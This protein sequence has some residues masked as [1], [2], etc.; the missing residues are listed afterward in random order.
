MAT[1]DSTIGA[2][3][4]GFALS[5]LLFGMTTVQLNFYLRHFPDDS[6]P[7]KALTCIVWL[8]E[9]GHQFCLWH[10]IHWFLVTNF[11]TGR[12]LE[13]SQPI[14]IPSSVFFMSFI[15]LTVQGFFASRLWR[16]TKRTE[17][18]CVLIGLIVTRFSLGLAIVVKVRSL[19]LI[20]LMKIKPLLTS[21][22]ATSA[23]TDL[24][25]TILLSYDLHTRRSGVLRTSQLIDRLIIK[26]VATG[27][28]TSLCTISMTIC[29][30][31]MN[32]NF[33]WIAI[34]MINPRLFSNAMLASLNSRLSSRRTDA[35]DSDNTVSQ[36][37]FAGVHTDSGMELSTAATSGTKN[38]Q[39]GNDP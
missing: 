2:M 14:S 19:T 28:L 13:G 37:R 25:V 7:L 26:I 29:F 6:K 10:I 16:V 27:M 24:L 12:A 23:A 32:G 4:I 33:I 15:G 17:V 9:L 8:A 20:N 1:I 31:A 11:A 30:L 3:H 38:R 36:F 5:T 21:V 39:T 35:K 18:F 34:F 22:W